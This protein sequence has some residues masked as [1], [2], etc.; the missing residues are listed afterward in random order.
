MS[1]TKKSNER[2][3][4]DKPWKEL[5]SDK[6]KYIERLQEEEEAKDQLR[7]WYT[8]MNKERND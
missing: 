8:N 4:L 5:Q 3:K 1:D 2:Y 7:N 6:R